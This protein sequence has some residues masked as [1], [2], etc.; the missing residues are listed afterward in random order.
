MIRIHLVAAVGFAVDQVQA[1]LLIVEAVGGAQALAVGHAVDGGGHPLSAGFQDHRAPVPG[2]GTAVDFLEL[3]GVRLGGGF[4][5]RVF[6]AAGAANL[7]LGAGLYVHDVGII[8]AAKDLVDGALIFI[9]VQLDD[10]GLLGLGLLG[11]AGGIELFLSGAVGHPG[12]LEAGLLLERLDRRHSGIAVGR[13]DLAAGEIA[14]F[15]QPGLKL[16]NRLTLLALLE[17]GIGG[18]F[19]DAAGQHIAGLAAGSLDFVPIALGAQQGELGALLELGHHL[20][21]A[22]AGLAQNHRLGGGH[23]SAGLLKRRGQGLVR[24]AGAQNQGYH[25]H[26]EQGLHRL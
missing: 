1:D 15:S 10:L 25:E 13:I 16:F 18:G 12:L 21:L 17:G 5:I 11:R 19:F 26:G 3:G 20:A 22:G 24:Q 7:N 4:D 8:P 23:G 14:Q 6:G 9:P 2:P